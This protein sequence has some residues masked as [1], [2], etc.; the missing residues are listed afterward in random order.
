MIGVSV[1]PDGSKVYAVGRVGFLDPSDNC[2]NKIQSNVYVINAATNTASSTITISSGIAGTGTDALSI[3]FG[4]FIA[5]PVNR[6][7]CPLSQGFW[8]G[9]AKLWP[10]NG[11]ALGG[12]SYTEAQLLSL[13]NTSSTG[14][15]ALILADELIAAKLNIANGS[16]PTPISSTV[17]TADSELAAVPA[18]PTVVRTSTTAGQAMTATATTLDSYNID[19]L[20]PRCTP[21]IAP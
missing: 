10:V 18:L 4:N 8:K 11:L 9:R 1:T 20:T 2:L 15:A 19:H 17:A 5:S 21:F 6:N 7:I 13:L 12:R 3:A 16:D 14:N